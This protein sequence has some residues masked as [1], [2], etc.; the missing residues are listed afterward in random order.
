MLGPVPKT[1]S[2]RGSGVT[3][4]SSTSSM[5]IPRTSRAV[6]TGELV[7][8]QRPPVARRSHERD[9][10]DVGQLE[11]RDQAG[12]RLRRAVGAERDGVVERALATRT[13]GDEQRVVGQPGA[14]DETEEVLVREHR[15][16]GGVEE[17]RVG[18]LCDRG[19]FVAL[20]MPEA[21]R[22]GD[23]HRAV[24][25]VPVTGDERQAQAITGDLAQGEKRLES[26][27]AAACDDDMRP[28]VGGGGRHTANVRRLPPAAIV[29]CP[30]S[31]AG[32]PQQRAGL[33]L[34]NPTLEDYRRRYGDPH[35]WRRGRGS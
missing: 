5:A 19:K 7:E 25:E 24:G 2:G 26:G 32:S 6:I 28:G 22:L 1:S 11:I 14:V 3:I 20:R 27:H 10:P 31:F 21:E 29:E 33:P 30:R 17:V 4:V 15:A 18:V 34:S 12:E 9:A 35:R 16:D 23:G 8:R 13:G